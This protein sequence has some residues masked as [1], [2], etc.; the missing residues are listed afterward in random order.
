[1]PKYVERLMKQIG[2]G[3]KQDAVVVRNAGVDDCAVMGIR[4]DTDHSSIAMLHIGPN[5]D[6]DAVSRFA[7]ASFLQFPLTC[8]RSFALLGYDNDP[9]PLFDIPEACLKARKLLFDPLGRVRPFVK[10]LAWSD[11]DTPAHTVPAEFKA[12]RARAMPS[13][14]ANAFPGIL[15]LAALAAKLRWQIVDSPTG[16][17]W[18]IPVPDGFETDLQL[19]VFGVAGKTSLNAGEVA[20]EFRKGRTK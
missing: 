3:R 7:T 13:A 17:T 6:G 5:E 15:F 16:M 11:I 18:M 19:R 1:M 14:G 10:L 2:G 9:R 12:W 4:G 8:H 20:R